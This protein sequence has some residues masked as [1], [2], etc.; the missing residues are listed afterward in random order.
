MPLAV[1]KTLAFAQTRDLLSAY[2][3]GPL[4][5]EI[6]RGDP[7]TLPAMTSIEDDEDPS[8][9][10]D[11]LDAMLSL[12]WLRPA[13]GPMQLLYSSQ[14]WTDLRDT[15]ENQYEAALLELQLF[16][17]CHDNVGDEDDYD[18]YSVSGMIF[19]NGIFGQ[20]MTSTFAA[21]P[22]EFGGGGDLFTP[23]QPGANAA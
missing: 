4:V 18:N 16:L 7:R 11:G 5:V 20:R 13:Q 15:V 22:L 14:G 19:L 21:V 17:R 9:L 12:I 6:Y 1:K 8:G 2:Q 3:A 23:Y 10:G